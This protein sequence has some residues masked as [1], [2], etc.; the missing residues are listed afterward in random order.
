MNQSIRQPLASLTQEDKNINQYIELSH[1]IEKAT[2]PLRHDVFLSFFKL[3]DHFSYL[4]NDQQKWS[5]YS[6][7]FELIL[8]SIVNN[9]LPNSW[10]R[11]CYETLNK[12]LLSLQRIAQSQARKKQLCSFY[13][14]LNKDIASTFQSHPF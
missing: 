6:S 10:R 14:K 12:P 8:Q 11:A 13:I 4:L 3:S 7:Q 9:T 2:M 1:A 5:L